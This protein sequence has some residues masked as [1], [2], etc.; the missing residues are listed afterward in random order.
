[1]FR[2]VPNNMAAGYRKLSIGTTID[3]PS[4]DISIIWFIPVKSAYPCPF[5]THVVAVQYLFPFLR[6][7]PTALHFQ[8]VVLSQRASCLVLLIVHPI[9]MPRDVN[10]T[11]DEFLFTKISNNN[12][13]ALRS[14]L[15]KFPC[16]FTQRNES[17]HTIT[18]LMA[19]HKIS[20]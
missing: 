3:R 9:G 6:P 16:P 10:R 11:V 18:H 12:S 2:D 13:F 7:Q 19:N 4:V 20:Q 1:V 15:E 17:L 14:I 5:P 8:E